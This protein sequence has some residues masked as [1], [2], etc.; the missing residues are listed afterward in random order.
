MTKLKVAVRN[1]ANAP[2]N[3]QVTVTLLNTKINPHYDERYS[4]YLT[5]N[6]VL[7]LGRPTIQKHT[8]H[9]STLRG[10]KCRDFSGVKPGGIYSNQWFNDRR[11]SAQYAS[12]YIAR[13]RLAYAR[14]LITNVYKGTLCSSTCQGCTRHLYAK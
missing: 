11:S 13:L 2:K 3:I 14:R 5:E 10:E 7:L 1:F 4:S 6:S 9:L 8:K 12:K